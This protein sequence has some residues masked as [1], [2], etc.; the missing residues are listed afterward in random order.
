MSRNGETLFLKDISF[1]PNALEFLLEIYSI[2]IVSCGLQIFYTA[3]N[4]ISNAMS[5]R[6][7]PHCTIISIRRH[8]K[9]GKK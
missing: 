8:G 4:E 9:Y 5:E 3:G 2:F 6:I 1:Y 7:S